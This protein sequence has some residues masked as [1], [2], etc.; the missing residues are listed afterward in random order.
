MYKHENGDRYGILLETSIDLGDGIMLT[1]GKVLEFAIEF[2][3]L[4]K[5]NEVDRFFELFNDRG[6]ELS[7]E[8]RDLWQMIQFPEYNT[9]IW[10]KFWE[11]YYSK[12]Y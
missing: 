8:E 11:I 2:R 1:E 6:D 10:N 4:L 3:E 9:D 5:N 7:D 12:T